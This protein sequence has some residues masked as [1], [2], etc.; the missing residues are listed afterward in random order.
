MFPVIQIGPLALQAPGLLLLAGLWLG[1]WLAEKKAAR[2]G[3]KPDDLYQLVFVALIAG[4]LG[5]RLVYVLRFPAAFLASPASLFSLNPGLLDPLGGLAVGGVAAA[6]FGQRRRLAFWPVLDALTPA[7]AVLAV[8]LGLAH[9]S[10]GDA[11]GSPAELP[12]AIE[13]WGARRHP[14]QVYETLGASFVL[15]LVWTGRGPCR[16]PASGAAFLS[17]IALSAGLRLFLEAFRDDSLLLAGGLRGAQLVAWLVLATCLWL[18][19]KRRRK[20]AAVV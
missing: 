17:F 12:W 10:A 14:S 18:L 11:Y 20:P 15:L 7:L 5:A 2:S 1:L 13:L 8:A 6:I 19:G 3:V 16:S 4:I 9:L